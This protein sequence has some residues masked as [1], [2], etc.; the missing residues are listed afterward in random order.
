VVVFKDMSV[1]TEVIHESP[2]VKTA[3][4]LAMIEAKLLC[5]MTRG[6]HCCAH[7]LGDTEWYGRPVSVKQKIQ[8]NVLLLQYV[9]VLLYKQ[10]KN[11]LHGP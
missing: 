10:T 1:E 8:H 4:A 6:Y 7:L 2:P 9:A 5:N 3:S 11:K